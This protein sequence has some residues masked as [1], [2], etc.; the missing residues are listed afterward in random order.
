ML[1]FTEKHW[2]CNNIEL[3]GLFGQAAFYIH[4]VP[5]APIQLRVIFFLVFRDHFLSFFIKSRVSMK[6]V[7]LVKMFLFVLRLLRIAGYVCVKC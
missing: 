5:S 6:H 3:E 2:P 4:G 1:P 7:W